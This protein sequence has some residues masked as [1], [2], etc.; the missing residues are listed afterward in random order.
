MSHSWTRD[1]HVIGK[2]TRVTPIDVAALVLAFLCIFAIPAHS[3]VAITSPAANSSVSGTV[4]FTC[5]NPGGTTNV[6][7]DEIFVGYSPYS[8]NTTTVANG[9][10]Y[11]SCNGYLGGKGNGTISESVTVANAA[12]TPKPT[13]SSSPIP[14]LGPSPTPTVIPTAAPTLAPTVAP[15]S[16]PTQASSAACAYPG[17]TTIDYTCTNKQDSPGL[18]AAMNCSGAVVRPHGVCD[19]NVG[20]TGTNINYEG[21]DATLNC[22]STFA[23]NSAGTESCVTIVTGTNQYLVGEPLVWNNLKIND[24]G[25]QTPNSTGLMVAGNLVTIKNLSINGFLSGLG[26][27]TYAFLDDI[28]SLNI[29]NSNTGIACSGGTEVEGFRFYGG[30]I[31]NSNYG[32]QNTGGCQMQFFGT[33]FDGIA[34]QPLSGGFTCHDCSIEEFTGQPSAGVMMSVSGDNAFSSILWQGGNIAQDASSNVPII[35]VTNTNSPATPTSAPWARFVD[36]FVRGVST[37]VEGNGMTITSDPN[38][39]ICGIVSAPGNNAGY[40][41]DV[42][43]SGACP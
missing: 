12:S 5:S 14:T 7:I 33:H 34:I 9:N 41:G 19:L 28:Y 39:S 24:I 27:G 10:Y 36:T 35:T 13:S 16:T 4:S 1:P 11:L 2:M 6:Y 8:W 26:F 25:G 17:Q 38:V 30:Q 15:S 21:A 29:W 31:F 22:E 40:N 42:S 43:N 23:P 18:Q 3:Q 32:L 37:T 20:L